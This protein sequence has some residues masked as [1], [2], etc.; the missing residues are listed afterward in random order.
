VLAGDRLPDRVLRLGQRMI[1]RIAEKIAPIVR[2]VDGDE[3]SHF[4][5]AAGDIAGAD[6]G[7]AGMA[8]QRAEGTEHRFDMEAAAAVTLPISPKSFLGM[9]RLDNFIEFLVAGQNLGIR[10]SN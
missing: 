6:T 2:G 1:D 5:H 3:V 7:L 8:G 9:L 10:P 4:R